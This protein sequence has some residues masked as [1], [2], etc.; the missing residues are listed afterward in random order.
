MIR[1]LVASVEKF[2]QL[3]F[4]YSNTLNIVILKQGKCFAIHVLNTFPVDMVSMNTLKFIARVS[5]LATFA[6][7][8]RLLKKILKDINC[9]M[10]R[11]PNV[12]FVAKKWCGWANT[13]KYI[14]RRLHVRS[15]KKSF[16]WKATWRDIC[17]LIKKNFRNARFVMN[18]SQKMK[19]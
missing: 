5:L 1:I 3:V 13:W 9:I 17:G 6:T 7:T 18:C 10:L 4:P 19:T 12:T 2:F 16:L 15:A 11:K 14:D 8:R